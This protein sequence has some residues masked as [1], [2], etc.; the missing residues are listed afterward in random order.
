M[1]VNG[2]VFMAQRYYRIT[3]ALG[4]AAI[5]LY[6]IAS[7]EMLFQTARLPQYIPGQLFL[8]PSLQLQ[9]LS[10]FITACACLLFINYYVR[11][12]DSV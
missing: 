1:S 10:G 9:Y 7:N 4:A 5:A 12:E 6:N 3:F 2:G 11:M 8:P